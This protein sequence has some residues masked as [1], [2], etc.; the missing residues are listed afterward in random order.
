M[1]LRYEL[2]HNFTEEKLF[3]KMNEMQQLLIG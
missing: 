2:I 1:R 3:D